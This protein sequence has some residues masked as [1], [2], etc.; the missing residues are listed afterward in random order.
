MSNKL[1]SFKDTLFGKVPE[2]YQERY[3]YERTETNISRMFYLSIYI[4]IIQIVLN[5][6]NILKPEDTK[7]SNIM[8]FVFLSIFCLSMGVLFLILGVLCKR[9]IIKNQKI[10]SLLPYALLYIY[11]LLQMTFFSLNIQSDVSGINS[12][13]IALIIASFVFITSPIINITNTVVAIS[14]VFISIYYVTTSENNLLGSIAITDTWANTII[15]TFLILFM[16][17]IYYSMYR[18]NFLN[19]VKME[20]NASLADHL[21]KI[22]SLTGISNRRGFFEHLDSKWLESKGTTRKYAIA[23]F[24]VDHFKSYNDYYG[25]LAGDNCLYDVSNKLKE[26]FTKLNGEVGRFGGEEFLVA[27]E[28]K[29]GEDVKEIIENARKTIENLNIKGVPTNT[30]SEFVTMSVG[31]ITSDTSSPYEELIN[32]ADMALYESK[33]TGR[34]KSTEYTSEAITIN[35]QVRS[36]KND[37]NYNGSEKRRD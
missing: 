2:K 15:I 8:V 27:F 33:N 32:L 19:K 7:D 34:N 16:S 9:N 28:I 11:A 26:Y 21:A 20:E 29:S 22:D 24:D 6:I 36:P 18:Q 25:H 37:D 35:R 1:N 23:M 30:E 3:K 4:I 31:Y 14:Y 5:V 10:R 12:Y 17:I 13:L